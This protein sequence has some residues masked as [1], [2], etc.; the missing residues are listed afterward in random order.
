M[1]L[2]EIGWE[3][4]L[5]TTISQKMLSKADALANVTP[6][7]E[8]PR[9]FSSYKGPILAPT[10]IGDYAHAGEPGQVGA[11][12][13]ERGLVF[14]TR[15]SAQ[16]REPGKRRLF[17]IFGNLPCLTS[18]L[19]IV[20]FATPSRGRFSAVPGSCKITFSPSSA[21]ALSHL[22]PVVGT[23]SADSWA[24]FGLHDRDTKSG[25]LSTRLSARPPTLPGVV[26]SGE[27]PRFCPR[28]GEWGASP[29]SIC[30]L[31]TRARE[32]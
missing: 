32:H 13:P 10:V 5:R 9:L 21:D 12:K 6:S 4:A 2:N 19:S 25:F 17:P 7:S 14:L 30:L 11:M 15:A 29:H 22:E 16:A 3:V 20:H 1:M 24:L 28:R 31:R 18:S 8:L 23:D 26:Y 27:P